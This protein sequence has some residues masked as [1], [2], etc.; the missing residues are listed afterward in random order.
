MLFL[1]AGITLIMIVLLKVTGLVNPIPLLSSTGF[2][3]VTGL[4]L[5]L[6]SLGFQ[7]LKILKHYGDESEVI[8]YY[9]AK[10]SIIAGI[11]IILLE[12]YVYFF[13]IP[14]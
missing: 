2:M 3:L 13:L 9:V 4:A 8:N 1:I 11:V 14:V 12:L 5:L 7:N 10:L 6:F